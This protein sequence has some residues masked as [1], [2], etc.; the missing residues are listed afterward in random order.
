MRMQREGGSPQV[1]QQRKCE[2][3]DESAEKKTRRDGNSDARARGQPALF[4]LRSS[5]PSRTGSAEACCSSNYKAPP[6][7]CLI[8]RFS[9]RNADCSECGPDEPELDVLPRSLSRLRR[10]PGLRGALRTLIR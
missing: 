7:L 8:I 1:Q 9:V 3:M 5:A 6:S 10:D 4:P 2:S